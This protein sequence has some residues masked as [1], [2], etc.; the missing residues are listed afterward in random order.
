MS[1]ILLSVR[2]SRRFL[3]GSLLNSSLVLMFC[4]TTMLTAM[5]SSSVILASD[6]LRLL[7]LYL[8]RQSKSTLLTS[9]PS[10]LKPLSLTDHSTSSDASWI[11]EDF[12]D[13]SVVTDVLLQ[14]LTFVKVKTTISTL[15][16]IQRPLVHSSISWNFGKDLSS[17]FISPHSPTF[18][19]S[20]GV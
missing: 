16:Q 14:T 6:S 1:S 11:V 3:F 10:S 13:I 7:T 4:C 19:L 20:V 17:T 18:F 9:N 8:H 12:S 15:C 2:N 5:P